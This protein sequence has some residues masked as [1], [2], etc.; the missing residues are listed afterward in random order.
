MARYDAGGE[1]KSATRLRALEGTREGKITDAKLT[2]SGGMYLNG[3][4]SLERHS[5]ITGK[6]ET[7]AAPTRGTQQYRKKKT[8]QTCIFS[9]CSSLVRR[10]E[11]KFRL[12]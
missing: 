4:C 5:Q 7:M 3:A 9:F 6:S 10:I 12:W 1:L 11:S 8:V 2:V